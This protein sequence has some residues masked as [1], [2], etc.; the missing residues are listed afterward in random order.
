MQDKSKAACSVGIIGVGGVG[1]VGDER[2]FTAFSPKEIKRQNIYFTEQYMRIT[3]HIHSTIQQLNPFE[4]KKDGLLVIK[5]T[6][7]GGN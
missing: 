7:D 5:C 4:E 3:W 6:H 1:C 2:G